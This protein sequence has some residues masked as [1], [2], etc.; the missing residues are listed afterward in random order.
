MISS[1]KFFMT[2]MC[3]NC[4]EIAEFLDT[5]ELKGEKIDATTDEGLEES[6]KYRVMGVPLMIFF[7]KDKK[8][9]NRATSIDEIKKLLENKSLLDL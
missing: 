2:P 8:E 9:V 7:D 6:R 1:Y 4:G 3:P 5:I